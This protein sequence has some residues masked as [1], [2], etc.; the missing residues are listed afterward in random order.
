MGSPKPVPIPVAGFTMG[1]GYSSTP[2]LSLNPNT[3]IIDP[4]GKY[5]RNL[6]R[7]IFFRR[8]NLCSSSKQHH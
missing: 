7:K 6:Y 2:G 3:G 4:A 8:I 1:G 5:T